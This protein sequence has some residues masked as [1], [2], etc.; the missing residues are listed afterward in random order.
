[1][2]LNMETIIVIRNTKLPVAEVKLLSG[3]LLSVMGDSAV[4]GPGWGS[5]QQVNLGGDPP[6][7]EGAEPNTLL[8]G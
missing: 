5:P 3:G 2:K 8:M 7:A 4:A 1:M 6:A